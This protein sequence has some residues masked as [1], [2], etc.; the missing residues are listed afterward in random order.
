MLDLVA[1]NAHSYF[2]PYATPATCGSFVLNQIAITKSTCGGKNVYVTEAGYPHAGITN[3]GNTPSYNNQRIAL[4]SLFQATYGYVTFFTFRDGKTDT[5]L[6]NLDYWKDPGVYGVEQ[7][8]G[9]IEGGV[10]FF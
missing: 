7:S 8:W 6:A 10:D 9:I 2:D 5:H 1:I 3:G 4:T